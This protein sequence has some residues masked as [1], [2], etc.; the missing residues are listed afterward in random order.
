MEAVEAG[1]PGGGASR[2]EGGWVVAVAATQDNAND[3][4]EEVGDTQDNEAKETLPAN[5]K[6]K[7]KGKARR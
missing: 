6:N 5:G 3:D 2:R 7:G 1:M 4:E